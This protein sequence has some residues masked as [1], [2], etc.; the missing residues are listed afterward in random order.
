LKI[1][2]DARKRVVILEKKMAERV[3]RPK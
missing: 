1:A 3:R 2:A